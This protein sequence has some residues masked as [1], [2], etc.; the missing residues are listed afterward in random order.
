MT[1]LSPGTKKMVG[2]IFLGEKVYL[3]IPY[4]Y[5]KSCF[6]KPKLRLLFPTLINSLKRYLIYY[7]LEIII[8]F[9][10][11]FLFLSLISTIFNTLKGDTMLFDFFV[12]IV[13]NQITE[14]TDIF[15]DALVCQNCDLEALA[16]RKC[17][18]I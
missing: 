12:D 14:F 6:S 13:F 5:Q 10:H 17:C 7:F 8:I 18:E 1:I 11:S 2:M 9:T 4:G 3:L 16:V 15:E